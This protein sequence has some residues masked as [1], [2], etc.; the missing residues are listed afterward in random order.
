M[1]GD[2][3]TR[4]PIFPDGGVIYDF[5][6]GGAGTTFVEPDGSEEG[7]IL[8]GRFLRQIADDLDAADARRTNSAKLLRRIADE[9][10]LLLLA[11]HPETPDTPDWRGRAVVDDGEVTVE[12]LAL[13][14]VR[15]TVAT[16]A[17]GS[18][19]SHTLTDDEWAAVVATAGTVEVES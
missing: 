6:E 17:H 7:P 3:D 18:T 10:D 13:G 14:G 19:V 11:A 1:S 2:Q 5:T 8:D 4:R 12:R 16:D 9:F 15:L